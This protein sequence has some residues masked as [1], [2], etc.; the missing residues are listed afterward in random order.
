MIGT[1]D[2][3]GQ[4]LGGRDHCAQSVR[5]ILQTP[6]G[7]R[8]MRRTFGS[9]LYALADRPM[10]TSTRMDLMHA[11]AEALTLW[12]PRFKLT[13]FACSVNTNGE[14]VVDVTGNYLPDGKP[15]QVN[16]IVVNS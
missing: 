10:N 7:T 9:D 14:V 8:V 4:A 2:Q 1:N 11:T 5:K 13:N 16:G 3:T 15:L 6:K 12:E